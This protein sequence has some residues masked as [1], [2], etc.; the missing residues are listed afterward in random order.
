M[1]EQRFIADLLVNSNIPL[2]PIWSFPIFDIKVGDFLLTFPTF[3]LI[4]V[5][6]HSLFTTIPQITLH[7]PHN[8]SVKHYTLL[9][10]IKVQV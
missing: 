1:T 3:R 7:T 5:R 2:I 8:S 4:Q 9:K 10:L 6:N